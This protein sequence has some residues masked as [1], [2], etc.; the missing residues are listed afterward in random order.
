[1]AAIR[2]IRT[3]PHLCAMEDVLSSHQRLEEAVVDA[4]SKRELCDLH[5]HLMGMGSA[6][7]WVGTVM[8]QYLPARR[9]HLYLKQRSQEFDGALDDVLK[10]VQLHADMGREREFGAE[11][12]DVKALT[13]E[14]FKSIFQRLE[15]CPNARLAERASER[16]KAALT[17]GEYPSGLFREWLRRFLASNICMIAKLKKLQS[18]LEVQQLAV[19]KAEELAEFEKRELKKREREEFEKRELAVLKAEELE[20]FEER[21]RA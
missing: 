13:A 1:V 10:Q 5:T 15:I 14:D 19:L 4:V 2:T 9:S 6:D 18:R 8:C 17:G 12:R 7:F 3:P 16:W 21:E 20:E 11:E